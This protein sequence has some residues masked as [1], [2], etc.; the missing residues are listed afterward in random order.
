VHIQNVERLQLTVYP[1]IDKRSAEDGAG[2]A[3]ESIRLHFAG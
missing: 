2:A 1:N 3:V